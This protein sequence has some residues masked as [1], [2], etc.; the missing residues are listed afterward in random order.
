MKQKSF[1]MWVGL[2][3]VCLG[4]LQDLHAQRAAAAGAAVDTNGV[5]IHITVSNG[6]AGYLAAPA[7]VL[8]GGGGS[9]AT[10]R[11]TVANGSVAAIQILSG[12]SGYTNAPSVGIA[13][14]EAL[15]TVLGLGR[16][17]VL[18]LAG[19]IGSAPEV[20]AVASL[21]GDQ[22]WTPV[23]STVLTNGLWSF[24]DTNASAGG[25]RFYR[26]V[27]RGG[28]RPATPEG[29]VWL[30]PGSFLMGS[31]LDDL[32]YLA[33]E[34]P[35]TE[36][37]L[38]QGFFLGRGEVSQ[39]EYRSLMGTNPATFK[40]EDHRP[41]ETVSWGEATNYC[42]QLTR[43]EQAAGRIPATWRYRLPTEAE[44]EY[45]ARAGGTDRFGISEAQAGDY[46]WQGENSLAETHPAGGQRPNGW[47]LYDLAGNV[48]EWCADAYGDYP[49]AVAVDPLGATQGQARVVRGGSY[50][51]PLAF[52][53]A[54]AR[55][56]RSGADYRDAW[57]GFR[58][59]LAYARAEAVV[60][61]VAVGGT[62]SG[63]VTI[64]D[65]DIPL[66]GVAVYLVDTNYPAETNDS[67]SSQQ[68]WVAA[69]VTGRDGRY[70]FSNVKPGGYGVLA[71][72]TENGAAWQVAP[73]DAAGS[74]FLTV[75][76]DQQ[77]VHFTAEDRS[78]FEGGPEGGQFKFLI[79][80]VNIPAAVDRASITMAQQLLGWGGTPAV[81][82][83]AVALAR[84][85]ATSTNDTP[86][87]KS[88]AFELAGQYGPAG[89]GLWEN[90]L[91]LRLYEK[92]VPNNDQ[93]V[94]RP[95]LGRLAYSV[96]NWDWLTG[97]MKAM[98]HLHP[99]GMVWINPGAFTM[100]SPVRQAD[101]GPGETPPRV[102]T[103]T[104]GF[105]MSQ[106]ETTQAEY[107]AVMGDNPSTFRDDLQRPVERVNWFEATNYCGKLTTRE[108][109]AGWLPPGY[110]YRL[111]TEAEWEYACRAGTTTRFS[112][113]DDWDYTS[114]TNYA[115]YRGAAAIPPNPVGR[116]LPNPWGLYDMHGNVWEWCQDW[117]SE[118]WYS[119]AWY[120]EKASDPRGPA[121]GSARVRRGG[122]A[123][124]KNRDC[125]SA[126]RD[127]KDPWFRNHELGFRVVLAPAQ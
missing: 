44:W 84:S 59:A 76:N 104:K 96:F 120:A 31:P 19:E 43:R 28:E 112:Y 86:Q 87:W 119:D 24:Q 45:A 26:A 79:W 56:A 64:K 75:S 8:G 32:D 127:S 9:N 22:A 98:D 58:V 57:I 33:N 117:Y 106:Y 1:L 93:V 53:R 69:T 115:R 65:A 5:V 94:V 105:W 78:L 126:K 66:A 38:T 85:T 10:A 70:V 62:V 116:K 89:S 71:M 29:M 61:P 36:V 49:G 48:A 113:G 124:S 121:K 88:I 4:H 109:L 103:I 35:P 52:C 50:L 13:P 91:L 46:A 110:V 3:V 72:K 83:N 97:E 60:N 16:G 67:Q 82:T 12:G 25:Q 14:P 99:P 37:R 7:I 111:P 55:D 123:E 21:G 77:T 63:R 73:A 6:G 41:V 42:A 2:A 17:A 68:T 108:R 54:G 100:G 125:R 11:A 30:P 74:P 47:G 90:I 39:G 118:T 101:I 18:T 23:K 40:G 92:G 95:I 122:G 114:L 27:A 51:A 15:V 34:G 80:V 20:Q 81:L 102:V 107:Q